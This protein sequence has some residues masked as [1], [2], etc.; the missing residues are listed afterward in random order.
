MTPDIKI[1]SPVFKNPEKEKKREE[2]FQRHL[3]KL[4]ELK[5]KIT[6]NTSQQIKVAKNVFK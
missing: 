2:R 3:S 5:L 6:A 1:Q 4:V